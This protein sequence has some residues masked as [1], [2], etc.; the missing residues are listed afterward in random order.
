MLLRRHVHACGNE[1]AIGRHRTATGRRS[2][3]RDDRRIA[4]W[5]AIG[6]QEHL[7]GIALHRAIRRVARRSNDP[8]ADVG[9]GRAWIAFG[10]WRSGRPR[11]AFRPLISTAAQHRGSQCDGDQGPQDRHSAASRVTLAART[12]QPK[13]RVQTAG[14]TCHLVAQ[15]KFSCRKRPDRVCLTP[16]S[17]KI[18]RAFAWKNPGLPLPHIDRACGRLA[19]L[20][21][22]QD[23]EIDP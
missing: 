2:L 19:C 22:A 4:S 16:R 21:R 11:L 5:P 15:R 9:A 10:A 20:H 14:G 8:D 23:D 17:G 1:R 6:R 18:E 3:G 12:P 13:R 7:I